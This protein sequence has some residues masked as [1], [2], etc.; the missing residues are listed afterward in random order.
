MEFPVLPF[1]SLTEFG[2]ISILFNRKAC[3]LGT[4]VR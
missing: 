3:A 1:A 2:L 4:G